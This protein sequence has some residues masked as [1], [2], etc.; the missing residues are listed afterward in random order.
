[1]YNETRG[2]FACDD[3]GNPIALHP[4]DLSDDKKRCILT[5]D[6]TFHQY[7]YDTGFQPV[8][9]GETD[10]YSLF[11][12]MNGVCTRPPQ[13]ANFNYNNQAG[14]AADAS[15]HDF[16]KATGVTM[17]V[18]G[19]T[20]TVNDATV[21]FQLLQSMFRQHLTFV[22]ENGNK[23]SPAPTISSLKI[24]TK[25]KPLVRY[26]NPV[27]NNNNCMDL[28]VNGLDGSDLYVALTFDY[29]Q[30]PAEDDKIIIEAYDENGNKYYVTKNAPSSGF[31]NGKYYYGSMELT[32]APVM[33]TDNYTPVKKNN[34]GKYILEDGY[35][36][37]ASGPINGNIEG[38]GEIRLTLEA[39]TVING[40]VK[41]QSTDDNSVYRNASINVE[42]N[43]TINYPDKIALQAQYNNSTRI[44]G[45]AT[46]TVNGNT[47]YDF[48]IG[49]EET[50]LVINGNIL[51]GDYTLEKET[52]LKLSG[53]KNGETNI[54]VEYDGYGNHWVSIEDQSWVEEPYRV[55]YGGEYVEPDDPWDDPDDPD[56]YP[57]GPDPYP[58]GPE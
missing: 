23:M 37:T 27:S 30:Y 38:R 53:E 4:S 29:S 31:Q 55:Y 8:D 39:G 18:V 51:N 7:S 49:D 45:G 13:Y 56:P 15:A 28:N 19:N 17:T 26:A 47:S 1:M 22:D 44:Y 58:D 6:L 11:Y 48:Y 14:T 43:S 41:L 20:L 9:I 52:L 32:H 50:T 42:G 54:I 3:E 35:N 36:Y 2:V 57:D 10:T 5:G 33:C 12:K 25:N 34:D 24:S 16:A 40:Y 46:L 21:N